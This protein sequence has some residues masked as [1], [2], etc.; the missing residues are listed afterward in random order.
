[1]HPEETVRDIFNLYNADTDRES[2]IELPAEDLH[3]L[4]IDWSHMNK[5]LEELRETFTITSALT[6]EIA[7]RIAIGFE[8]R[9]LVRDFLGR[10]VPRADFEAE[11][12]AHKIEQNYR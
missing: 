8:K 1:M 6:K 7:D 11:M 9:D 5:L 10:T 3:A 4:A 12:Q 2:V